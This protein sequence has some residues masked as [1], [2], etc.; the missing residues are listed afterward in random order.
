MRRLLTAVGLNVVLGIPGVVPIAL[1]YHW[2]NDPEF[3]SK[4]LLFPIAG[5]AVGIWCLLN[6]GLWRRELVPAWS[7]WPACVVAF[8]LPSLALIAFL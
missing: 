7:Y 1:T 6:W 2:L 5:L 3:V 8:F 4:L